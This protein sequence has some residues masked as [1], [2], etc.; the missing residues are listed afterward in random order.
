VKLAENVGSWNG[1][2]I[3][4]GYGMDDYIAIVR[5]AGRGAWISLVFARRACINFLD[6]GA[7]RATMLTQ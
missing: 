7:G 3:C 4:N 1:A 5:V 2:G 6:V